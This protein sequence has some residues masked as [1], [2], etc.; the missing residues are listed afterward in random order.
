M[1]ELVSL[2]FWVAGLVAGAS[3]LYAASLTV[4]AA[5]QRPRQRATETSST[6]QTR[7]AVLV[8]A[9]D[10]ELLIR[11]TL[12]S[13]QSMLYPR[14]LT[15]VYVIADNCADKTAEIARTIGVQVLERHDSE[16][17][18]KG[19]AI[20]WALGRI[21]L[22]QYD[23]VAMFDA[24]TIVDAGFL[25]AMD[26]RL[27]AG[28]DAIQGYYTVLNPDT[29]A[30]VLR[31]ISFALMHYVRPL[32]K[33]LFRGSC[34]LKGNGMAFSV[35]LLRSVGWK[36]FS[37]VE[38]AEQGLR[39]VSAGYRIEFAP[40]A[41]VQG[42]MPGS[43]R[44]AQSQNLRWEAGRWM[45]ARKWSLPLIAKGVRKRSFAMID[46]ALEP[47]VP[48]LSVVVALGT[49]T[50]IA[51]SVL[52]SQALIA[53]GLASLACIG[54]HVVGGMLVAGAP[55]R[56]WRALLAAPPYLVWKVALYAQALLGVGARRWVRTPRTTNPE[57]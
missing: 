20:D 1:A 32:G 36:S 39:I 49:V 57:D 3:S 23:A 15:D 10:E 48:P 44:G 12:D 40:E 54:L 56:A 2:P 37:V 5:I 26:I 51:G 46:A 16:H 35:R 43:L 42:E 53:V 14:A 45:V 30:K 9:H 22:T 38:D 28:A 6:Q 13:I 18:G 11:R 47:M 25:R 33:E 29:T 7:F 24:D 31:S 4:C 21:P 19:Y 27:A 52:G 50:A 34:G 8:P 41:R 17:R 55:P